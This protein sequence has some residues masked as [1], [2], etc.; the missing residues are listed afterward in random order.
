V[1]AVQNRVD[2]LFKDLSVEERGQL[3]L[4]WF[5]EGVDFPLAFY[6]ATP[7]DQIPEVNRLTRLFNTTHR[8]ATWYA[9]W[10]HARLDAAAERLTLLGAL[11]L[12]TLE[13]PAS[14]SRARA[15]LAED[16]P[17]M[18]AVDLTR[19][20]GE[21]LAL[22]EVVRKTAERFGGEEPIHPDARKLLDDAKAA[23]LRLV[24][25]LRPDFA[26]RLP[27]EPDERTLAW[28]SARIAKLVAPS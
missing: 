19:A 17:L 14:V 22:E 4:R 18:V 26:L 9:I 1:N 5:K 23:T 21:L 6:R 8:E 2:R 25:E 20:W 11:Q 10:L 13:A 27:D 28:L 24:E 3:R 12:W 16:L 15:P 7:G